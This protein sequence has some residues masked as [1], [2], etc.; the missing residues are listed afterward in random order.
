MNVA[1]AARSLKGPLRPF[2]WEM[3]R[4][5]TLSGDLTLLFK[6]AEN[7]LTSWSTL[8][9]WSLAES[10]ANRASVKKVIV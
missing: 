2:S 9:F 4:A 8:L 6:T 7:L 3:E 5:E 10:E 1:A